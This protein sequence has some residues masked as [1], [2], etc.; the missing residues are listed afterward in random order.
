MIQHP[1]L[2]PLAAIT[3]FAL[4]GCL[5]IYTA[6]ALGNN[7]AYFAGRQLIWLGIGIAVFSIAAM[8]PFYYYEKYAAL[9]FCFA[10]SVLVG[11]LIFGKKI[12]GMI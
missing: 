11:V 2:A 9:I 3:L 12:N 10:M 8:I 1:P 7:P 5:L 4:W 6:K